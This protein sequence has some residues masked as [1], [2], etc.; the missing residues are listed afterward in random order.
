MPNRSAE[1]S[2]LRVAP[3]PH[4]LSEYCERFLKKCKGTLFRPF[5]EG[6]PDF[7]QRPD[8]WDK[9]FKDACTLLTAEDEPFPVVKGEPV[10]RGDLKDRKRKL[11]GRKESLRKAARVFKRKK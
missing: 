9:M 8:G 11:R 5:I 6:D 7:N 10:S 4:D 2:K 3:K 1:V